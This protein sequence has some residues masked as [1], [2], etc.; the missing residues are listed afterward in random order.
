MK[1]EKPWILERSIRK[2]QEELHA[3]GFRPYTAR[4]V[5]QWIYQKNIQ[6]PAAWSN[7]GKEDREKL[8]AL[9]ECGCRPVLSV[10]RDDQG[11]CKFL[12]GLADG[13]KI[14]TVLIREKG[15]HTFCLSTQVG[16][17]LAC[18]F[19]AT[20]TMGLRRNLSAGE[21]V[22]QVLTL[23]KE[24]GED[25]AKVNLVFMGMGEPLLNYANLKPALQR[26]TAAEGLNISPR[27]VTVSTV[28]I[29]DILAQ[30]EI[31]FPQV[32]VAFSLN[33]PENELRAKLMPVSQREDLGTLLAYFKA[34]KRR[35]RLTCE[36]VLLRGVN[37]SPIQARA[38]ARLLHG[39]P[40]KVN[41][42]PY[43]E[44]P[45]LPFQCP[46][47]EA[48]EAFRAELVRRGLTVVTRWSK[49]QS[50]SSACGQLVV[51]M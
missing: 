30:L 27:H 5:F 32:K 6:Q 35:Q 13:L 8:S 14:E 22:S 9:Y 2:L 51:R 10:Q 7:I 49:G 17:A 46:G 12:I 3:A 15:H 28:G 11:T 45:S 33:A 24:L 37:D 16:C 38:L 41:L 18:R 20:G 4:Q 47:E 25:G 26:I 31:D 19:C 40:A 34:K 29:L 21:I 48:V 39:I 1:S 23:K 36:Y 50:I 42:I 44:N 43:N